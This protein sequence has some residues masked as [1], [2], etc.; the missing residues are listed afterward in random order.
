MA[1]LV[2]NLPAMWKPWVQSPGW[3]DSPGEERGY[4]L[5]YSGL[6]NS[7]DCIVHGV[8]KSW[9]WLSDSHLWWRCCPQAFC[10]CSEQ[11]LFLAVYGPLSTVALGKLA[12]LALQSGFLSIAPPGRSR[13]CH[14]LDSTH[15]WYHMVFV[16]LCLTSPGRIISRSIHVATKRARHFLSHMYIHL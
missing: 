6:E 10:S 3:E 15:E 12:S 13:L 4:P 7:V 1:Q 9:T 11:R 16:F 8:T 2:K 14:I 5:Q